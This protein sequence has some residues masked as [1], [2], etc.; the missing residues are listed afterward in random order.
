MEIKLKYKKHLSNVFKN[1]Y[2][3]NPSSTSSTLL[4]WVRDN[5]VILNGNHY[6]DSI[7]LE[8]IETVFASQQMVL[9][10]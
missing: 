8:S 6:L 4:R 5:F 9:P 3:I 10:Q 1:I 2:Q 7:K